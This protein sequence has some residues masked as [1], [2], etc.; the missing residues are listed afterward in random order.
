MAESLKGR[1]PR[2]C[3]RRRRNLKRGIVRESEGDGYLYREGKLPSHLS[4]DRFHRVGR[5]LTN[6][7]TSPMGTYSPL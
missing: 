7:E 5:N 4:L 1:N 3:S 6:L 2:I